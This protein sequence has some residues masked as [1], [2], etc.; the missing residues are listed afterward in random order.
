[1]NLD[2]VNGMTNYPMKVASQEI[3]K[4]TSVWI[5]KPKQ[6][7]ITPIWDGEFLYYAVYWDKDGKQF[8]IVSEQMEVNADDIYHRKKQGEQVFPL[9]W[10]RITPPTE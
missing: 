3:C 4:W 2:R 10:M 6:G 1:M 8:W 9:Y 5:E 7:S